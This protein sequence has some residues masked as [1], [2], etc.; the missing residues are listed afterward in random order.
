[1]RNRSLSVPGT[2]LPDVDFDAVKA[3]LKD[4]YDLS[5]FSDY[6]LDLKAVSYALYPMYMKITANIS[7]H[8]TMLHDLKAM[9]TSMACAAVRRQPLRLAKVKIC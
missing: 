7:R 6:Q 5:D 3:M 1:M 2:L 8:T 9:F 4:K